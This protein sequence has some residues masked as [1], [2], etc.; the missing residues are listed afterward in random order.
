MKVI[1]LLIDPASNYAEGWAHVLG[2]FGS[3]ASVDAW[4]AAQE[5]TMADQDERDEWYSR[6]RTYEETV[7]NPQVP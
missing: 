4:V 7:D 6:L 5:A 2:V 3:E 1:V